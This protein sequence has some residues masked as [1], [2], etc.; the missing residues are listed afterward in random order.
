M[1]PATIAVVIKLLDLAM[2]GV[3]AGMSYVDA[4]NRNESTIVEI[5][6]LRSKLL[7]GETL[8]EADEGKLDLLV[9]QAQAARKAAKDSVPVPDGYRR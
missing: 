1:D 7:L 2:L 8:D 3:T 4:R 6:R 5:E 9:R